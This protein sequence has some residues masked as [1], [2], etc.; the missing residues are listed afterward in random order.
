MSASA[1]PRAFIAAMMFVI[2]VAA[3]TRAALTVGLVW[4][5]P[6]LTRATSGTWLILPLADTVIVFATG[7][8]ALGLGAPAAGPAWELS[9]ATATMSA[10]RTPAPIVRMGCVM[11][12]TFVWE[13]RGVVRGGGSKRLQLRDQGGAAI[14]RERRGDAHVMQRARIIEQP[15]QQ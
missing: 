2:R 3:A 6:R 14:P 15:E 5:T 7:V 1:T 11:G 13:P 10:P 4:L 8:S 9:A 12:S